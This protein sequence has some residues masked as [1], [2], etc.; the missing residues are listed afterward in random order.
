MTRQNA[1]FPTRRR[2]GLTLVELIIAV[3][4]F[5]LVGLFVSFVALTT[6]RHARAS[7]E[8]LP[9]DGTAFRTV[10]RV[11]SEM[12]P[13]R[14]GTVSITNN[15]RTATFFNPARGATSRFEFDAANNQLVFTPNVAAANVNVWARNVQGSF[16]FEAGSN[17]RVRIVVSSPARAFNR[18]MINIGY[19]DVI[20]VRN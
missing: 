14:V 13:A 12:L 5:A 1:L 7:L 17:R 8:T 10:E 3:S 6:A 20:T 16:A 11:R 18:Q 4:L 15:G 9:A 2:R 19:S